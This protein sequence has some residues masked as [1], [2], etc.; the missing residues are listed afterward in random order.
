MEKQSGEIAKKRGKKFEIK[1]KERRK[2]SAGK[3]NRREKFEIIMR[4]SLHLPPII[5][6][7]DTPK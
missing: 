6:S 4:K 1:K 7:G 5:L 3:K 2:I